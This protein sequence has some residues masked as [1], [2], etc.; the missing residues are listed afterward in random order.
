[1]DG[2]RKPIGDQP[3]EVYWKRRLFALAILVG[4]ILVIWA[5]IAAVT[6]GSD[7]ATGPNASPDPA[8]SVTTSPAGD[9]ESVSRACGPTDVTITAV[10][11]PADVPVAGPAAFDVSLAQNGSSACM[12]D[13]TAAGTELLITSGSDRIYSSTDCPDD[14]AFEATQLIMEPGTTESI[15]I[16]WNGQR[17]L[18]KCATVTAAPGAGTYKAK[19]SIQDIASEDATFSLT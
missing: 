5:V 1:M 9:A 7:P 2:L 8:T 19:V 13:T 17:S 10:A 14:A 18:P 4:L 16:T 6:G 12:I 11:N 3:P 15:S